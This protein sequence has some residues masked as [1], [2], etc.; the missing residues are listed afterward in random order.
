[1]M[2]SHLNILVLFSAIWLLS[3]AI[4]GAHRYSPRFGLAPALFLLGGVTAILQFRFLGIFNIQIWDQVQQ[5]SYTS[6]IL[7][8]PLLLGIL[9][10]Y[11]ANDSTQARNIL[12]GIGSLSLLIAAMQILLTFFPNPPALWPFDA[13]P[14]GPALRLAMISAFTLMLDLIVLILTYQTISN[15]LNRYPS[16]LAITIAIFIALWSDSLIFTQLANQGSDNWLYSLSGGLIA[17]TIVALSILPLAWIYL[18]QTKTIFPAATNSARPALDLF[19]SRLQL[20]AQARYQQSL[21][22]TLS[23]V[24]QLIVRAT[25]PQTLLEQACK[26]LVTGRSYP[27][28]WIGT[29]V[30]HL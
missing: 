15:L 11:I 19:S 7:L 24:N 25:D 18:Q 27:L 30:P 14:S 4:L 8:P 6:L 2:F 29:L 23:Q 17:K 5:L 12:A 22:R 3:A 26:L 1:M 20:E 16:H 28:V 21:L 13:G 10:I 9:F